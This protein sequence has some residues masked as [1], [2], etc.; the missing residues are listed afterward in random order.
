V[1]ALSRR[2]TADIDG[3]IHDSHDPQW[4][5]VY[6]LQEFEAAIARHLEGYAV[7]QQPFPGISG[8]GGLAELRAPIRRGG[9]GYR[10]YREELVA[11]PARMPPARSMAEY[12]DV[13]PRKD[14]GWARGVPHR[15]KPLRM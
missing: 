14:A 2:G 5:G 6:A 4:P 15:R 13:E 9:R 12:T 1:A 10:R 8:R 3:V 11:A 7:T